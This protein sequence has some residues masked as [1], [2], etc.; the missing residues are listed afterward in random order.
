MQKIDEMI[1][2]GQCRLIVSLDDVRRRLPQASDFTNLNEKYNF[3]F[4]KKK[5]NLFLQR[6]HALIRNFVDEILCIQQAA[7]DMLQ[8]AS[9]DFVTDKSK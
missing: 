4:L 6:A 2:E 9:P 3:H 7:R 1:Q 8:R 5:K